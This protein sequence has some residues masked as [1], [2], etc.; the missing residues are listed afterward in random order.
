MWEGTESKVPPVAAMITPGQMLK[1]WIQEN[2][3]PSHL[4]QNRN[5]GK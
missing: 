2:P 4:L 3:H 1:D 5:N